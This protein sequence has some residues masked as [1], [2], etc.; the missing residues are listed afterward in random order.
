M[1][2]AADAAVHWLRCLDNPPAMHLSEGLM[3]QAYAQDGYVWEG[4]QHI[5]AHTGRKRGL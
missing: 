4:A 5:Q 3:A 1:L 2:Q